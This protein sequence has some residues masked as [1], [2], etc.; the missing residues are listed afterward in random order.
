[1]PRIDVAAVMLLHGIDDRYFERGVHQ[2][3]KPIPGMSIRQVSKQ[4]K[5]RLRISPERNT[6]REDKVLFT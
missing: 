2:I 4:S 5:F 3:P 1:M 6:V